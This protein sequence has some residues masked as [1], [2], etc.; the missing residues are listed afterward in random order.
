MRGENESGKE[1]D[2][3]AI[4]GAERAPELTLDRDTVSDLTIEACS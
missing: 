1:R 2:W 4:G 3:E